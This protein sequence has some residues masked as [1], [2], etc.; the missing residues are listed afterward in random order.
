MAVLFC[1]GCDY[2]YWYGVVF[3]QLKAARHDIAL[4]NYPL[5][6]SGKSLRLVLDFPFYLK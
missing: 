1:F 4:G 5:L 3:Q 2:R 6:D